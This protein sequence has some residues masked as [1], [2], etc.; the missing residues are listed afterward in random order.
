MAGVA[1]DTDEF[2]FDPAAPAAV[3]AAMDRLS[4]AHDGWINLLPGVDEEEAPEPEGRGPFTLLF[5]SPQAP[6]T[7]GTWM[8]AKRTRT[9]AGEETL[10]IMHPRG[11]HAIASLRADGLPL[12][13]GWR[14]RQ[15]HAR[16]GLIVCVPAGTPHAQ[17]L[18]W[19]L[20]AGD[21]LAM[22]PLT[23]MW[24]A[25]VFLPA[26]APGQPP[27]APSAGSSTTS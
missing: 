10:G 14:V 21:A 17:V 15:D 11:R 4:A 9:G 26:K 23:G 3:L 12:P 8:P 6:V 27:S 2:E 13:Q 1:R 22:V 20:R 19:A 24:R 25:K 16:R 7:M 5:G 18:D